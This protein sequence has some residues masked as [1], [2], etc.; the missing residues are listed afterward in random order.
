MSPTYDYDVAIVSDLRYPGGNSSSIV[1]EV[2]AQAAAGY[3]T[4]LVHLPAA[5]MKRRRSFNH[6]VI[7]CISTGMAAL[8]PRGRRLKVRALVVRQPRIFADDLIDHPR[9]ESDA[10]V[11]VV[12]HPP[13]DGRFP[14]DNPYYRPAEVRERSEG[15]FGEL[16]WAPIGPLVRDAVEKS[17]EATGADLD[18]T[19]GDWHNVINVDEWRASRAHY[20]G[21]RPIIGRHSRAHKAKWLEDP[22]QILAA[23]PESDDVAVR[24]LGGA[25][26][27]IAALGRTPANWTIYPF[28]AMPPAAFLRQIDFFVYFHH[29]GWVEAF[30]RNSIEAM[31][32][33]VPLILPRN[34]EPLFGD[35]ALYAEPTDVKPMVTDLYADRPVYEERAEAGGAFV[36]ENFGAGVHI[37]RLEDLIGPP[38]TTRRPTPPPRRQRVLLV[39]MQDDGM[40]SVTRLLR[41]AERLPDHLEPVFVVPAWAAGLV[42]GRGH[43]VDHLQLGRSGAGTRARLAAG[44][45]HIIERERPDLVVADGRTLLRAVEDALRRVSVPAIWVTP[46]RRLPNRH[47]CG[48]FRAIVRL[49]DH[50]RVAR[51]Y[52]DEARNVLAVPPF[53]PS[54]TGASPPAEGER[55]RALVALGST[56]DPPAGDLAARVT[57][58]LADAGFDPVLAL[59]ARGDAPVA[60][61]V[62]TTRIELAPPEPGAYDLA[63]VAAP[64]H[65]LVHDLLRAGIPTAVLQDAGSE[66]AREPGAAD[67]LDERRLVAAVV[68]GERDELA[69]ALS[70]LADVEVRTELG[71]R[72]RAAITEDGAAVTSGL[73]GHIIHRPVSTFDELAGEGAAPLVPPAA[74]P[75]GA[76]R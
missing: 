16:V 25:A 15:L 23:Y 52:K 5:H 49:D 22:E 19:P 61:G 48:V 74:E 50:S 18:L 44:L 4:V 55:P 33:G 62:P 30:G 8:A 40:G 29:P 41:L 12:N 66:R 34:F 37:R 13:F 57:G 53:A 75:T 28:G 56:A 60:D 68:A 51:R 35:A 2:K 27:A 26:P 39:S 42:A 64:G 17:A 3:S 70:V 11:M 63:V 45:V 47:R 58:A 24:I 59:P 14:L 10:R 38:S 21:D 67:V 46:R 43:L 7:H 31:A 71:E 20:V 54:A 36:S 69:A 73:A 6:K 1:E 65:T 9:I 72:G 76:A 32:S